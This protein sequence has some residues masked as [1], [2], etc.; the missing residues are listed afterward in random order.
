M[1]DGE[2][3]DAG[4]ASETGV[5]DRP[6]SLPERVTDLERLE[7]EL[8]TERILRRQAE[9]ELVTLQRAVLLE[10]IGAR[11]GLTPSDAIHVATGAIARANG[12]N[13]GA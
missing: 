4:E 3:S 2:L 1:I 8:V 11:Y 5:T 12:T 13:G 10:R 9:L 7:L 6:P